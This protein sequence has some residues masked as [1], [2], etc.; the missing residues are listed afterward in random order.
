VLRR[1][2]HLGE[3]HERARAINRR[4]LALQRASAAPTLATSLFDEVAL[5]DARAGQRTVA[6]R[7][8]DPRVVALLGALSLALH[9][10]VPFRSADLRAAVEQLLLRPYSAAQM[11]YDLRRLRAKGLIA[12][13]DGRHRYVTTQK[14]TDVALFFTKSYQRFVRP[15]L[16]IDAADAPPTTAPIVR[17]ALRTIDHY[18]DE[19]AREVGLAA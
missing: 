13:L 18:I 7:Y 12:R 3:L 19:R 11:R 15:L 17:R 14:G 10:L 5:P 8:G 2:R 6:L 16:A 4:M 9:Q 1:L